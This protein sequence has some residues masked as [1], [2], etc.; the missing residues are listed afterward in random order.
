MDQSITANSDFNTESLDNLLEFS[1]N[2]VPGDSGGAL[3][4]E[5]TS[6]VIGMIVA[7][8]SSSLGSSL[9]TAYA[10]PSATLKSTS[11]QISS[12]PNTTEIHGP[13]GPYLGV[14]VQ[15]PTSFGE[16]G[17]L[18][19]NVLPDTPTSSAGLEAGDLII[20]IN[21]S[22]IT[23]TSDLSSSLLLLYPGDSVQLTYLDAGGTSSSVT[24]V[25][26]SGPPL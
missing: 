25:L 22:T 6:K 23:S 17:A 26:G 18:I 2:I 24:I 20:G 15:A 8:S 13:S 14:E 10:I 11:S 7:G 21:S 9:T 19:A 4:D 16:L 12:G 3:I 5:S 1:A